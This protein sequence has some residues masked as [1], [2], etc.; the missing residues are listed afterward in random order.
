[1]SPTDLQRYTEACNFP[2]STDEASVERH[3]TEYLAALGIKREVRRLRF[4]R[5]LVAGEV[6]GWASHRSLAISARYSAASTRS[7]SAA[8]RRE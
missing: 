6:G 1:M 3:L 7:C 2:G 5:G 8:V 4:G